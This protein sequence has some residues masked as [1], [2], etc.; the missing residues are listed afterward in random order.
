M[1]VVMRIIEYLYFKYFHLGLKIG[2]KEN[3]STSA[4]LLMSFVF[5]LYML[6]VVIM[7]DCVCG[8]NLWGSWVVSF[9]MGSFVCLLLV[10]D[11]ALVYFG[12]SSMIVSKHKEEWTGKKHLGAILFPVIAFAW[13]VGGCILKMLINQGKL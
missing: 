4:S 7:L 1:L 13:F 9:F 8:C 11:F 10:F 3:A 12:R 6:D 5:A 2:F